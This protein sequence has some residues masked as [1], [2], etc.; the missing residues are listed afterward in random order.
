[1]GKRNN[2]RE[3][4]AVNEEYAKKFERTRQADDDSDI[5]RK[6]GLFGSWC[7]VS[8]HPGTCTCAYGVKV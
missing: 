3:K 2:K 7:R 6:G 8:G 1:M 5:K 4:R